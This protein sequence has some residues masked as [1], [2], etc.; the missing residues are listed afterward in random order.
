MFSV[1]DVAIGGLAAIGCMYLVNLGRQKAAKPP[2][3]EQRPPSK[4]DGPKTCQAAPEPQPSKSPC[5][6]LEE[7]KQAGKAGEAKVAKELS[8]LNGKSRVFHDVTI[9]FEDWDYQIDHMVISD[10]T[11]FI[12]ET[13]N[14]AGKTLFRQNNSGKWERLNMVSTEAMSNPFQQLKRNCSVVKRIIKNETNWSANIQPIA[15][16]CNQVELE[17]INSNIPILSPKEA[18]SYIANYYHN[19]LIPENIRLKISDLINAILKKEKYIGP[20]AQRINL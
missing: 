8:S 19:N 15:V 17:N 1:P 4:P 18:P 14:Y 7:R 2:L 9:H 16:M 12:L 20:E 13:K 6:T 11:I 5:L 10:N 3:V